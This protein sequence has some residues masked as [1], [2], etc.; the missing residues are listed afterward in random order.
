MTNLEFAH[1]Y[2]ALLGLVLIALGLA[3][4]VDNPI[5]GPPNDP[6]FHAGAAQNVLHIAS[7]ALA[8][9][10]AFA[11]SGAGVVR[12][13]VAFGLAYGLLLVLTVA[14]PRLFGL[15]SVDVNLAGHVLHAGVAV[16]TITVALLA[17]GGQRGELRAG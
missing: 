7:G 1:W 15:F 2:A 13:L 16:V 11:L 4:F 5:V 9:F 12:G 14:S 8:L 10:T 17:R 6:V 3:G